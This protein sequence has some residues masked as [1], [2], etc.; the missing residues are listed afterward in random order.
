MAFTTPERSFEPTVMFFGLTSSL[1][2]FQV[3]MNELLRDLINTGK[4]AAF[5][6]DVIVGMET[7]EG[8]NEIVAEIIKRLEKNDLYVKPK[9][10]KWKVREVGFLGVVIR[11][12]GI[13]MEE[14]KVKGVLEWLTPKCVK[15]VQKFLGLVN[16][17]HQFIK[18]F[19]SIVRPLHNLVKKDQKW[20]WT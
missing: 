2:T 10:Y 6:D 3:I 13:K 9:K 11:L 16:Y 7:E 5:I 19:A 18:G 14:E 1:A 8:H 15:N 4:V 12:E 17:Y 20:N